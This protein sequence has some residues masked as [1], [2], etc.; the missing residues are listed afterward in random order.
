[1]LA[2]CRQRAK[3]GRIVAPAA[4][5]ASNLRGSR[6]RVALDDSPRGEWKDTP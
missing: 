1:V 6:M 4:R 5:I 2:D 3:L